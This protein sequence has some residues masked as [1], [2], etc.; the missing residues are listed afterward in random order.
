MWFPAEQMCGN[1]G[2]S[3]RT[4]AFINLILDRYSFDIKDNSVED[5]F[6]CFE[7]INALWAKE[8]G[9]SGKL[10]PPAPVYEEFHFAAENIPS[11]APFAVHKSLIKNEMSRPMYGNCPELINV[12]P[13]KYAV[14][15]EWIDFLCTLVLDKSMYV[16]GVNTYV[17]FSRCP[18]TTS[19]DGH[20][21]S[22]RS[23]EREEHMTS[24]SLGASRRSGV[25]LYHDHQAPANRHDFYDVIE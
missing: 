22:T 10:P 23:T 17:D 7:A 11:K 4:R 9:H 8:L 19:A 21:Q 16:Y 1:G 5:G 20:S 2:F 12:L 3:I 15:Q 13:L 18:N 6:I 25:M 24:R 14:T